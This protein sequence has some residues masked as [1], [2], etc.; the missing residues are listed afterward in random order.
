M[1]K[2]DVTAA[3]GNDK[4]YKQQAWT[5]VKEVGQKQRKFSNKKLCWPICIKLCRY[6]LKKKLS[7]PIRIKMWRHFELMPDFLFSPS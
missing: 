1:G 2:R 4:L 7:R 3:S 5:S 6:I